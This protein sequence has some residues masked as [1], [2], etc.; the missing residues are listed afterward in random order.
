MA[1]IFISHSSHDNSFAKRL[2]QDL[3]LIGYTPWIDDLDIHPGDDIVDSIT[4]GIAH[5][6]YAIVVLSSAAVSSKWV[7]AEWK[8][9]L[10]NAFSNQKIGV[11][12]VLFDVC[13]VPEFLNAFRYA[14]FTKSYAVGF[15]QLCMTLKPTRSQVPDILD[16]DF[17][18]AIE[19]SA[20]KHPDDHIRLACA[21]TV[22][23]CRPDRAKPIL[24]DAMHDLRD[25]VRI[26]AQVLLDEF[27]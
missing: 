2:S 21:H 26:H 4:H 13:D 27:Y 14:D 24:E 22:W 23:S 5:A 11:I 19:D 10:R 8:A 15:A 7:E 17:L 6:R 25:V 16:R 9:T 20:R 12:P 1:T 3:T 18:L